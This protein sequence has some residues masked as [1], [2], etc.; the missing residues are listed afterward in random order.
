MLH[1]PTVAKTPQAPRNFAKI[2][3]PAGAEYMVHKGICAVTKSV[4]ATL[5]RHATKAAPIFNAAHRDTRRRQVFIDPNKFIQPF[6]SELERFLAVQYP[7]LKQS[8]WALLQSDSGC[9]RQMAHIDFECGDDLMQCI[10]KNAQVPMLALVALQ[11]KTGIYVWPRSTAVVSGQYAGAPIM[12]THVRL[13]A[14]DVFVFRSD[15]VHAGSE[16]ASSNMRLHCYLDSDDVIRTPNRTMIIRRHG[17]D[18]MKTSI[19]E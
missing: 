12:A 11:P 14:G 19:V 15:L 4:I 1:K 18:S 10:E 16:Y 8:R 13:E 3:V 17:T 7:T 2:P 9:Q 6:L 5:V